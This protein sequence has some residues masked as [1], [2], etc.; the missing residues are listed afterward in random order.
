MKLQSE[1]PNVCQKEKISPQAKKIYH[2]TNILWLAGKHTT[3]NPV[4]YCYLTGTK[5]KTNTMN[6]R[7][8]IRREKFGTQNRENRNSE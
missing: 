1:L 3:K 4:K 7:G 6:K 2:L 8:D 5:Q